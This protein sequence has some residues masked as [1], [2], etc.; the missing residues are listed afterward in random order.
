[1]SP[2]P[3][4]HYSQSFS[5]YH[6]IKYEGDSVSLKGKEVMM[7]CPK[8]LV[9]DAGASGLQPSLTKEAPGQSHRGFSVYIYSCV[10]CVCVAHYFCQAGAPKRLVVWPVR[11]CFMCIYWYAII[12]VCVW[13]RKYQVSLHL[14]LCE[15]LGRNVYR[16]WTYTSWGK[17]GPEEWDRGGRES[18]S[19]GHSCRGLMPRVEKLEPRNVP[20]RPL[21]REVRRE[22]V[23]R[24]TSYGAQMSIVLHN[25]SINP[26][27]ITLT[28]TAMPV[29][30]I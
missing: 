10:L 11:R 17:R 30:L 9:C 15:L 21:R 4:V 7:G 27:S 28:H 5:L 13:I 12:L 18:G 20:Q 26:P 24:K 22:G 14:S 16:A 1:M 3:P 25:P 6:S 2:L 23:K 19:K 8:V 29:S